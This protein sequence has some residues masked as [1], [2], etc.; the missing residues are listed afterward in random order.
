[1]QI[2][3][4]MKHHAPDEDVD[5][6]GVRCICLRV[7]IREHAGAP[8]D[9]RVAHRFGPSCVSPNVSSISAHPTSFEV[10]K[11]Q[12]GT[13]AK[14]VGIAEKK[15]FSGMK[16]GFSN[17]FEN[18]AGGEYEILCR[19]REKPYFPPVFETAR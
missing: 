3:V 4:D 14:S 5:T 2:S 1:M 8:F 12:N 13:W 15:P 16:K 19:M 17:F 9:D 6:G 10:I 18:P 7:G 11:R